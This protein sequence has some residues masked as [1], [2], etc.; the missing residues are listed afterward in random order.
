MAQARKVRAL[1]GNDEK[2][3]GYDMKQRANEVRAYKPSV[4]VVLAAGVLAVAAAVAVCVAPHQQAFAQTWSQA[5]NVPIQAHIPVQVTLAGD[6]A[7]QPEDFAF[8]IEPVPGE[9][10]QP[11][12]QQ[13]VLTGAGKASFDVSFAQ[14]GE[15]H[16]TVYQV[17][18]NA[19]GWAYDNQ[20]YDVAVY[21]MWNGQDSVDALYTQVVVTNAAGEKCEACAFENT[22]TAPAQPEAATMAQTGDAVGTVALLI[23]LAAVAAIAVATV[24]Y[25]KRTRR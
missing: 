25:L 2:D 22:Y 8:A 3:E 5:G 18:G 13:L 23:A 21:C 6:K 19:E 7:A 16:Y 9:D 24:A 15:H 10:A 17:P 1:L 4:L 14:V 11:V 20:V 12:Q